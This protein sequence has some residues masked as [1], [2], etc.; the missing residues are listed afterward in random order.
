MAVGIRCNGERMI[1]PLL[2]HNPR[3]SK[4]RAALELLRDRGVDADIRAYLDE[5]PD[6]AELR[7]LLKALGI[8]A[9]A[10]LRAGEEA[11][12]AL[13][14]DNEALDD[15]AL[16]AAMVAQPRLIERPI[17]V[18]GGRAAIGRPTENLLPLLDAADPS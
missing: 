11:Y 15:E 6:A 9:R 4:S 17:L 8:P 1:R 10:L 13:G 2:W 12:A 7:A 18:A 16:I 3:C 14:L 5:P